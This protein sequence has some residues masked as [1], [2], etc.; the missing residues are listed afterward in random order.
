M[1]KKL[2]IA[3]ESMKLPVVRTLDASDKEF[4][5]EVQQK[6]AEKFGKD[7][8]AYKTIM[9]GINANNATGSQYFFN[10]EAG[11]YLPKGQRVASLDDW[12]VIWSQDSSFLR[13]MKQ[14][15]LS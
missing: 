13:G 3:P 8:Q 9:N 7:S 5:Q 14:I 4:Y 6:T 12:D 2:V 15:L 1:S 10:T 11:L